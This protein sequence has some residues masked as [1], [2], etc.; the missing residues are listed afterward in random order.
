MEIPKINKK[1][2]C[3]GCDKRSDLAREVSTFF[4]GADGYFPV[5]L[6]PEVRNPEKKDVEFEEDGYLNQMVGSE[7]SIFITNALAR[8]GP[9]YIIIAGLDANQKTFFQRLPSKRIIFIDDIS[10][11]KK[12]D[13][14]RAKQPNDIPS[15]S[16]DLVVIEDGDDIVSVV[17]ENFA[18][19]VGAKVLRVPDTER[20]ILEKVT[21][22]ID[23]WKGKR[24]KYASYTKIENLVN[25]R[26]SGVNFTDFKTATFFTNGLPYGLV[27]KNPIPFSYVKK[28]LRPDIFIVNNI[29][30][31]QRKFGVAVSFSIDQFLKDEPTEI[32]KILSKNEI[33]PIE[34]FTKKATSFNL[35]NYASYFPYDLLHISSHGGET[36]GYYVVEKFKD[37]KGVMHTVE[38]YEVVSFSNLPLSQEKDLISVLR[39]AIFWKFDG[40]PWMSEGLERQRIPSYVFEDMRKKIF[41]GKLSK[42][43]KRVSVED[44][45]ITSCTIS[46]NQDVH[47][48]QFKVLAAHNAPVVFN[49]SCFSWGLISSNF[50][51]GGA[52]AYVGTLWA[53][54][55]AIAPSCA[56]E[57][58]KNTIEKGM[59]IPT[60]VWEMNNS[61]SIDSQ[62]DIFF[63]WALPFSKLYPGNARVDM[64]NFIKETI[65]N[66]GQWIEKH[67]THPSQEVK[68]NTDEI[69]KFMIWAIHKEFGQNVIKEAGEAIKEEY[70]YDLS[71][72]EYL[73]TRQEFKK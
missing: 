26:V 57:F 17:A 22:Y 69:I 2:V 45:I 46:T 27:L 14:F 5:F 8:I 41:D 3:I 24:S 55:N 71:Q 11:L 70:G 40:M 68:D 49:N 58:Y 18:K 38:Y 67:V 6:F 47:Q 32:S 60:A 39:K 23:E 48:G 20:R 43:A 35:E 1:A 61:I 72:N 66:L 15:N 10:D 73:L 21:K 4:S 19:A 13:I 44:N 37:R 54:S 65:F 36:T 28:L 64:P 16:S 42:E 56:I 62:K 7:N 34:L 9:E 12:H 31:S 25:D 30:Y 53:I 63:T 50:L 33:Y 29:L 59:D 51:A 52:R